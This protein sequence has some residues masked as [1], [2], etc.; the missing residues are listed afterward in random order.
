M[1]GDLPIGCSDRYR[2]SSSFSQRR[3]WRTGASE[4]VGS[5]RSSWGIGG[6]SSNSDVWPVSRSR[7]AAP[8]GGDPSSRPRS[9]WAGCRRPACADPRE[10]FEDFAIAEPEVDPRAEVGQRL[11]R[12]GLGAAGDDRLD[13]AFAD[14]LDR[15]QPEPDRLGLDGELELR[16]VDVGRP[17]LDPEP[18]ALAIAAATFSSFDRNADRTAVMY[19]TVKFALR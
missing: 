8:A 15:Q 12:A 13:R 17:D 11:V 1:V 16:P 14:V 3:R 2:P 18:A 19:S 7:C 6:D 9:T 5:G 10:G 4:T